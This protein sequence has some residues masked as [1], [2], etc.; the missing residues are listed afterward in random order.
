MQD[1]LLRHALVTEQLERDPLLVERRQMLRR[2][3]RGLSERQLEALA[4]GLQQHR[5]RLVAG[6]LFKSAGGGGCAV[7]VMLREL[8]AVPTRTAV[9]FW[10]RDRWRRSV[11]S[12]P[13]IR[14]QPR[15][16]HLEWGFD[17]AVKRLREAGVDKREAVAAAGS[18]LHE[19]TTQELA[20]RA[21]TG[22]LTAGDGAVEPVPAG[23]AAGV[24]A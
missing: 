4:S 19:L 18:W 23:Q 6:R 10:L 7:G 3:L 17:A 5:G 2:T 21:A 16:R 9:R 12:Y 11:T 15:L 1:P 24:A 20:W 13:A 8:D 22:V 14:R